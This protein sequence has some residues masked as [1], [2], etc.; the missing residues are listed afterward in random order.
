MSGTVVD[1]VSNL[2]IS[3]PMFMFV[4]EIIMVCFIFCLNFSLFCYIFMR[5]GKFVKETKTPQVIIMEL[6]HRFI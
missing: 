3:C 2:V 4:F 5:R 6:C 1:Y